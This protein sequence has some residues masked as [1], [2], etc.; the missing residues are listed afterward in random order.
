V[1]KST[2]VDMP[3]SKGFP[4]IGRPTSTPTQYHPLQCL[5]IRQPLR[6]K[7]QDG[8]AS[9]ITDLSLLSARYARCEVVGRNFGDDPSNNRICHVGNAHVSL[10]QSPPLGCFGPTR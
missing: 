3:A 8:F 10:T 6:P 7:D 2:A 4:H 9:K 1:S 5:T